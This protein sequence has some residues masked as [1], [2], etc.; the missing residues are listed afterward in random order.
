MKSPVKG[1][2]FDLDGT[3][4]HSAIDFRKMKP[5]MIEYLASKG[6]DKEQLSPRDLNVTIISKGEKML[7]EKG[8]PEEEIKRILEHVE[9]IMNETE[10]EGV[11]ETK[12]IQ[13]AQ[14][15]LKK[16]KEQGYKTAILTRG[17]HKYAVEALRITGL[18]DY[19]DLVI[20]REETPKPKPHGE[21]LEHAAKLLQLNLNELIFVGDHPI[22][23]TCAEN[24]KVRFIGVLTGAGK[25]ETWQEAGCSEV[26]EGIWELPEYLKKGE[27]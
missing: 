15:A 27:K 7:R 26:I 24:A 14:E 20:G 23:S 12:P 6:A 21:A 16:I 13:G 8:I 4:V 25:P 17:H 9:E 22:D 2:V 19:F 10:M 11:A 5:R 18:L 3:L 1:I